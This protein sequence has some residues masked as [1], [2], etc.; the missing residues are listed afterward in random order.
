VRREI[1]ERPGAFLLAANHIS[2]FD[3]PILS[4]VVRRK[5]DWLAMAEFFPHPLLGRFLRAVDAFPADRDRADRATIR[6]AIERLKRGC[7]VGIFPEGGIRDGAR[8]VLEG[9][10][11]RPGASALAHLAGVPIVPCV[12]VGTDRFY[13]KKSWLPLRRTP[14][15]IAFGEP[16]PPCSELE[17]SAARES[18]GRDLATAFQKLYAEL[19]EKFSLTDD[20]LPQPPQKRMREFFD[21]EKAQGAQK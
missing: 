12:I 6:E 7:I 14:L 2:H 18:I 10:P 19:R 13:A 17:K 11:L 3:P 4:S 16:I 21:R 1:A 9:A 15:W 5:I 8:S 20:D